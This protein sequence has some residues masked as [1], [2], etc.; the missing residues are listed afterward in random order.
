[1]PPV[2]RDRLLAAR[3]LTALPVEWE[4]PNALRKVNLRANLNANLG[5]KA[6]V[7][8]SSGFVTSTLRRPQTENNALGIGSNGYGGPG[9]RDYLVT[10]PTTIPVTVNNYGFRQSTPDEMFSATDNQDINRTIN[11]ITAHY[12]PFSWLQTR[13]V[14]GLDFIS[15][16]DTELCRKDECTPFFPTVYYGYKQHN[17]TNFFDYT[18]DWN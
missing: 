15:R 6:D 8:V 12:R 5:S 13:A 18:G 2:F 9:F 14:A 16:Q 3:N 10:H 7:A 1:M 17:R 11:S 4:H